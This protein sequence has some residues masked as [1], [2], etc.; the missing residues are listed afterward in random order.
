MTTQEKRR[1]IKEY[2][3]LEHA[4]MFDGDKCQGW[5]RRIVPGREGEFS[6][7]LINSELGDPLIFVTIVRDL[8]VPDNELGKWAHSKVNEALDAISTYIQKE[9]WRGTQR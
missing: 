8:S 4:T 9:L 1:W 3:A 6:L 2:L 7:M 5:M